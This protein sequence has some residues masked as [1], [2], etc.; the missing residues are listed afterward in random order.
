MSCSRSGLWPP[1]DTWRQIW[2]QVIKGAR[3]SRYLLEDAL[4]T[5]DHFHVTSA[6]CRNYIRRALGRRRCLDRLGSLW[7]AP[8]GLPTSAELEKLMS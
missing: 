5:I 1:S 3:S 6:P 2:R 8:L 7:N 4:R